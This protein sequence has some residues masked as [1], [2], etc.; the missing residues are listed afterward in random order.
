MQD[1]QSDSFPTRQECTPSLRGVLCDPRGATLHSLG[2][3]QVL[4]GEQLAGR[5]SSHESINS[6]PQ[7]GEL[8]GVCVNR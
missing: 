3:S 2:A 5:L 7:T 1:K 6:S 8:C 4:G